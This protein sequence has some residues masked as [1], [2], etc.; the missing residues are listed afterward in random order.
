[1][2]LKLKLMLKCNLNK[3]RKIVSGLPQAIIFKIQ[4]LLYISLANVGKMYAK[5]LSFEKEIELK[6]SRL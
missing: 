5:I 2:H 6:Y 4:I 1:M 3:K